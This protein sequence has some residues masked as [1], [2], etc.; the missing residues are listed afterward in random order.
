[1]GFNINSNSIEEDFFISRHIKK[2]ETIQFVPPIKKARVVEIFDV[3]TLIIATKIPK[4]SNKI[5]RFTVDIKGIKVPSTR[6]KNKDEKRFAKEAREYLSTFC[7]KE[8]IT[9]E[10]I[11]IEDGRIKADIYC[12][13]VNVG[14]WL[15][16]MGYTIFDN[17]EYPN[18]WYTH[19]IY[20]LSK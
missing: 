10:N 12:G 15:C 17:E 7:L 1:M 3:N 20:S 19:R 13:F 8:E 2:T 5:Y 18:N 6:S 9:L 4:I 16:H 11:V 14:E